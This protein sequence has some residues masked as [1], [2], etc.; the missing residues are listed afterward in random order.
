MSCPISI[1]PT[2]ITKELR[3]VLGTNDKLYA[4][5]LSEVVNNEQ[6]T[7]DF[8]EWCKEKLNIVPDI[9][10]TKNKK[11]IVDAIITYYNEQ[12]PD[13]N[14]SSRIQNES[15]EVGRFGYTSIAAREFAKRIASNYALDVYHQI[16]HE[17]HTTIDGML[18]L[19]KEKT[20]K[21]ITKKSFVASAITAKLKKEI[22][23]RLEAKGITKEDIIAAFNDNNTTQLETWFEEDATIQD[24]NV[25]STYK[26]ML[27]NREVFFTEVFRDS[28][29]GDLRFDKDDSIDSDI[30]QSNLELQELNDEND[31][32]SEETNNSVTEDKDN[33]INILNNKDGQYN[34][35][36]THVNTSVKSYLSSLKRLNSTVLNDGKYDYDTNNDLGVPDCMNAE[37]CSAVLYSY[38]DFTNVDSMIASIR[39]IANT[40]PGF[41]S[42]IQMADYLT[43]DRDFAYKIYT[44]FGKSVIS[45]LET[46]VDSNVGNVRISNRRADKLTALRFE[47]I[48]SAKSTTILLDDLNSKSIYTTIKT[49][50]DSLVEAYN[51]TTNT[52]LLAKTDNALNK[53]VSELAAQLRR[54]YPTLTDTAIANYI[55][56]A[57]EGIKVDNAIRLLGILKDTI[58]SSYETQQNYHS[59]LADIAKASAE[60][61]KKHIAY[62]E[63]YQPLEELYAQEYISNNTQAAAISLANELV[64]YTVVK[65]ELNSRNVHGN[66]SSDVINNSMI[67][68]IINTLKS[69]EG[70]KNYGIYK[71]QSRQYDFSNIMI[72][73]K[74][75]NGNIINY[76]LFTQDENSQEFKPTSYAT[77][78]L[79]VR[80][81]NGA[82]ETGSD[83][84]VLY[85]EMSKGDYIATSFTNF[86]N[87][88][89]IQ[90]T[91]EDTKEITFAEYFMRIPSDAPKNF[92]ICAPKYSIGETEYGKND[93]LFYIENE[94]EA[95]NKINAAV[96]N[97]PVLDI[98]HGTLGD[99]AIERNLNQLIHHATAVNLSNIEFYEKK[100]LNNPDAKLG[101][102]VRLNFKHKAKDGVETEY[103]LEGTLGKEN[104][105]Y[106]L[107]NPI[108]KGFVESTSSEVARALEKH[109]KNKLIKQ[110]VIKRTINTNHPIYKQF[111]NAF[112]QELTDAASALNAIFKTR[113]GYVILD[114]NHQPIF[115]DGFAND[116][117]TA[118]KLYDTYHVG[119]G[120][121]ILENGKLTGKV[122]TSDRFILTK[123]YSTGDI[124]SENYGEAILKEAFNFLYGGASN[125]YIHTTRGPKG[126]KVVLTKAQESIVTKHLSRFINDYISE[127]ENRINNYSNLINSTLLTDNN[128]A[129]YALN[130][131]LM[132][133]SFNDLFEGD[134]KFYKDTQTFLKRAKESQGSGVPYGIVDYNMDLTASRTQIPSR[135]NQKT[136]IH[137]F[138]DGHTENIEIGQYNK[139]RG[140]TIKN[141]IRTS[142]EVA[143]KGLNNAKE[144]GILTKKLV[145]SLENSGLSTTAATTKAREMMS[146]YHNTKVNDAQSYIT[147]EE[148]VR[149]ISARGQLEEYMPLIEAVLD[150][151]KPLDAKTIGKFIQVQKNFYYDQYYNPQ[152]GCIVPRQIKN[153]EFVLVPRLIKG[154]QL[155]QVYNMMKEQGIDQLNTEETSKAGKANILTIWDNDGNIT[156][157]NI[158]DFN[159][160][161]AQAIELYNYNYLYTQQETPQHLNA[162][163]KAGIQIMKKIL[164]NISP[165]SKL[166]PYKTK[167]FELYCSNIKESFTDLID[168]LNLETDENGNL[169][170]DEN[171]NIKGLNYQIFFDKLQE[172]VARLG[173]DSNM[174][175]YVTLAP[176]QMFDNAQGNIKPITLMPTFMSNVSTKLENIAQSMFNSSITRQTLPG[177]HVAQVT[178]VGWKAANM[179]IVYKLNENGKG[180]NLKDN[181]SEEE[182]K[183]V[184]IKNQMYYTKTKDNIGTSKELKYHP[185]GE[186]Y[187]EILLPKANF[188]FK[189]TK[190]DGSLKTDEELL[191]ELQTA[192]LDKMIGYRIPT[193]GKQ[194]ICVMKVVGFV[195][196]ALGSTIIVPDD[197]VSQTGSDFDIDSVYGI[198]YT[199][200]INKITGVIEKIDYKTNTTEQDYFSYLRHKLQH[201]L[202]TK[203]KNSIENL[204]TAIE[205]ARN[206]EYQELMETESELYHA[207]P[208][209][210]RE[211]IKELQKVDKKDKTPLEAY[212]Q[213]NNQVIDGLTQYINNTEL[214]DDVKSQV[215]QYIDTRNNINTFINNSTKEDQKKYVE[216]KA[217]ILKERLDKIEAMAKKANLPTYIQFQAMSEVERNTRE[218]RNNELLR[219]MIEILSDE[220]SLEENLS[221]SNF[222]DIIEARDSVINENIQKRR[223]YRSTFNIFDQV[224]YQE[225]VMSGAKLKAFSVTRDTFC[226]ICNTVQ[227]TL[228]SDSYVTINY[229]TK[230]T[231]KILEEAF[232]EENVDNIKDKDNHVIGYKVTHTRFGWSNTNKNV[233]GKLITAY[234]SQTTAH[235]LDAVK[236]GAIPNVND[237]TFQVYKLFPDL[238]SDYKTGISF[239]MQ[240]GISRIVEGYNARNSIYSTS[241]KNPIHYAIYSI[242]KQLAEINNE[243]FDNKASIEDIIKSLQKYNSN[244]AKLFNITDSKFVIS[245][246]NYDIAKLPIDGSK[247]QDRLQNTGIFAAT[248]PVEEQDKLLFDLGVVLQYNK[249]YNLGSVIGDYARV[250]NPD[251]FGAK[252]SIFETNKVFDDISKLAANIGSA[253]IV[254]DKNHNTKNMISAIYPGASVGVK[255]YSKANNN[256]DSVYPSLHYFLKYATATSIIINRN[257]F[258]TQTPSFIEKVTQL[259]QTFSGTDK[260]LTEKVYKDYQNYILSY[261]YNQTDAIKNK[262]IYKKCVGFVYEA[263]SDTEIERNRIYGYGK[264]PDI[265]VK[266]EQGNYI[267]FKVNDINNPSELE[268]EQFATLSPA[269]KVFWIQKHFRESGVFK[270]IRTSLF[271]T[272]QY[273]KNKAG[274]QTI[275]FIEGNDNIETIYNE[276]EKCYFNDNPLIALATLDIVKYGF[277]VE[278]FKMK[279]N[280]V[281]KV[282][283][284]KVLMTSAEEGGTGIVNQIIGQISNLTEENAD[285][286]QEG[287]VR[288]HSTIKEINTHKVERN[289]NGNFELTRSDSGIIYINIGDKNAYNL[290]TRYGFVYPVFIEGKEYT[291]VNQYVKLRF[292]KT[293]ELYKI[294]AL[295]NKIVA[296]PLNK[297]EANEYDVWSVNPQ[298]HKYE[299]SSYYED[300]IEDWFN[301][302][303]GTTFSD[304]IKRHTEH[305]EIHKYKNTIENV[306]SNYARYFDINAKQTVD[307][308]GF[309]DVINKTTEYFRNNP[310]GKL[311]LRSRAL[312]KYI[313]HTGEINGS[314]QTINNTKYII[315]KF[316]FDRYNDIYLSKKGYEREI[317]EK[318]PQIVDI[319]QKARDGEYK[320][321]D[322][323]VIEPYREKTPT[324]TN[325][326][327]ETITPNEIMHSS[328]TELGSNSMRTM[329]RR[330]KSENDVE[331]GKA[332]KRLRDKDITSKD[333]SVKL[334]LDEVIPITAE[335]VEVTTN[336]LLNDLTYFLR[337]D[338]GEYHSVNDEFT[339]QQIRNNPTERNRFLKTLLD[340]RAFVRNYKMINELDIDSEDASLHNALNRIKEA[341]NKLQNATIINN[342]E[343]RFATDFLAKLSNNPN[344]QS[345]LISILDGYHSA[346]AFD[347][348]VNDLQET[349]NPLL[350]IVTKE[351]MGDIRAKE[352]LASKRI[353]E[354]KTQLKA[355]KDNAKNAGVTIDWSHIIDDYGKFIQDYNQAFIDKIEELRNA[356][357]TAKAEFDEGSIEHLK[358]KFEYDKFKLNHVNQEIVDDYYRSK[359]ELEHT[360]LTKFPTVYSAYRKLEAKRRELLSHTV[361][362][363]LEESYQEKLR[364][365]KRQ[366]DNLTAAYYYNEITGEFEEKKSIDDPENPFTGEE[367]LTYS[368]EASNAIKKYLADSKNLR[369]TYFV[370][371]SKYGFD[372][373]LEKNLDIIRSF[374]DKSDVK[375][376]ILE[377]LKNDTYAKARLW[378]EQN[379]RFSVTPELKKYIDDAFA[380]FREKKSGRE[381]L[382]KIAK[383][384]E[385]YDNFGIIDA[386]K[387][388][389]NDIDKIK[390]EETI[391]YNIREGE[392]HNDRILISNAPKN[393]DV[394]HR[395]FYEKMKV[396][397]VENPEYLKL[398]TEIND[399]LAPYY[400]THS[401]ILYTYEISEKDLYDL[402]KLYDK[403][404]NTKKT[405]DATNGKTVR[406]YINKNVDFIINDTEYKVQKGFAKTKGDRY[407]KLWQQLC[408]RIEE[409][410]DGNDSVI[411]NRRI[412][413]YA[414]P[415]GYKPDGT[416]DNSLVDKKKTEAF[417]IIHKYTTTHPTEYY[418]K[419]FREM[420][421]KSNEEFNEWYHR[422]HIYNPYNHTYQPLQCWTHLEY[423]PVADDGMFGEAGIWTPAYNQMNSR[424]SNGKDKFGNPDGSLDVTNHNYKENTSTA[425][426]FKKEGFATREDLPFGEIPDYLKDDTD[427]TNHDVIINDYEKQIKDLFQ[428]TLKTLALTDSAK[429]YIN[430]GYMVARRKNQEVDAKFLA[431]EAAKF[432]GWIEGASGREAW[433]E[434]IDYATDKTIDMPM[435]SMLKSKDSIT[436]NYTR[437]KR[438]DNET[439]ETYNKRVLEYE[440]A[441]KEAEEQNRKVHKDLLDKNWEAVM[442]DFINKACHFNAI[443]DNKYMLFYAKNMLDKLDVYVKNEGFNNL[444]RDN[445]NST[446]DEN[447][448]VTRK[449]TRLQEQYVNWLRRLVYDQWKK[450]NNK[451]TRTANLLQSM[452]SAKFMMLNVTGGIA[453]VTV[454]ETQILAEAFANEYFGTK[455]WAKGKAIWSSNLPNFIADM[456]SDTSTSLGSAI[457]KFMNVVDFDEVTGNVHIDNKSKYIERARDLAFSPQSIGEHFM[458][459]GAMFSMMMSHKLYKNTDKELN[460]KTNY[461]LKNE[462]EVTRDANEKALDNLLTDTLRAKWN[463][464]KKYEIK[465]A[466]STKEYAWF[467]KDLTTEFVNIYFNAEEK[468]KFN[469]ECRKLQKLYLNDFKDDTK[470]PTLY[471]QLRLGNNG[472]LDFANGSIMESLGDEAYQILGRFKGRVISVNKKIHGVY[473]R[474]GAAKWESYWW[475]GIVMQY[476]KHLYPG[477]MKRYRRQGYFNEER[478]T[479]EKGCYASIKDFLALPLHKIA[480]AK[481]LQ[482]E[483][484]MSDSE[485]LAVKGIQ[486]LIR[487]YIEFA[488]HIRTNWN[489]I[490]ESERANIRRSLGDILGVTAALCLAIAL[491][492]AAGDDDEGFIYNL[493]MYEADR[494]ASESFMYNPFGAASEAEK[495]WSSPVAVQSGISDLIHSAGF[496]SQWIIQGDEFDPYY[497]TGLY[498]GEN[499]LWV[500]VRRQIP[501]YHA[502]NML[503]RL[504]RNNHYYKLGDNMLSIVPVKDIA[505]WIRE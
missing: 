346:G 451:L 352:M 360:M 386:T 235:I 447:H 462:A 496:I 477:I 174:M 1:K 171:G 125:T 236:E 7:T 178:N 402:I 147:F 353:Q 319:I 379:A 246:N 327:S 73:H 95:K 34:N 276:F 135:L 157:E 153:A 240:P 127:A 168:E 217:E 320:V 255:Y 387:F 264:Q 263:N 148:W 83:K 152:L 198:N 398:V 308:G 79:K 456:Y 493:F 471:S 275:E 5:Y 121:T 54:Y 381:R 285:K 413:G 188:G 61:E 137:K 164:D 2:S 411:A 212:T 455:T 112:I 16:L 150:E 470:H 359:L 27:G 116:K 443:Q 436:V 356:R 43:N 165:N 485:I 149:R 24:K 98:E 312:A 120:K 441:K 109:F 337:D 384:R 154:T 354:F 145:T 382:S 344:I 272:S 225:D 432:V 458:Q 342:A 410:K 494:L 100:R 191:K 323:F 101:D 454:G 491:R 483:N 288:S 467:R 385:A 305:K 457:V 282:I 296:Y 71:S 68:N 277:A 70:L 11:K 367:K 167:F 345:D 84:S 220:T 96:N 192:G 232:G 336:K 317:K 222:D 260:Q 400:D 25:I 362:G 289:K 492:V 420:R 484:D 166:Y 326:D 41:E 230:Y 431:K 219:C 162:K 505:N 378:L 215:Q 38:C 209:D 401:G 311:Y 190:A 237:Y 10:A 488:F 26:E 376:P 501:M 173:L 62:N 113:D 78:L 172:E 374:E 332:L 373:E 29:L 439:E 347:A 13:I 495:L 292:G 4:T 304:V 136:F 325:D 438:L 105:K 480:F 163:N 445:I 99:V 245:L 205:D 365:V 339:I 87:S 464:F 146:G 465:D 474:L 279:R 50:L 31:S 229:S 184:P 18:K 287:F 158:N 22:I 459:N 92:V 156:Q 273:Y 453:N 426:N 213:Q 291:K 108:F 193:E 324:I 416:G 221:R 466:N 498:A 144:D 74:D 218:A 72:E 406:K 307:T 284:N 117:A 130:H 122:F 313:K 214:S 429:R 469:E 446:E 414:V 254:V 408:E 427:Y 357:D 250:C 338:T 132:Y 422:N 97:L 366:I 88:E 487:E 368:Y 47:Y 503:E 281:N 303:D 430:N 350:Q 107:T 94:I 175:D 409:D 3:K 128:I 238:G 56:N 45:K 126:V 159:N 248:S 21:T 440:K 231:R 377:L 274:A 39:R 161:A 393:G 42:F 197:W 185:N 472:K 170:L 391:N 124:V 435:T 251:K 227:P 468:R 224:D 226:S 257:L 298:Y 247:Y 195:D 266:N 486:N 160:N 55:T 358:A 294:K 48:N 405:L 434:D 475:G 490:P 261:F 208:D 390:E 404:E 82:T 371:D 131:Y 333:A 23:A 423:T 199:S 249:L 69:E 103:I 463:A 253:L 348:W 394:F 418:Y 267:D 448:Y 203:V 340:A 473:D 138:A 343:E 270:Y 309:E 479:I 6:F 17:K 202:D 181:I 91:T 241:Y 30:T 341:I 187:I 375:T 361:N 66:Q 310:K 300:L 223:K 234:S 397:G 183:K 428:N 77:E 442:E 322:A 259:A 449:D 419:K 85:S 111:Y 395:K 58:D 80:L 389:D 104:N 392:A 52:R 90:H 415:K 306:S 286:L 201:K 129:E 204:K 81:F 15:T 216:G 140:V 89:P 461:I 412:F 380:I 53:I 233:V 139:F 258:E 206:E 228:S 57:H 9:N 20:G 177:F 102:T 8:Q 399:I 290:A 110:G 388:T 369:D 262:V 123:E 176:D 207:L 180:R 210:I 239:I 502:W 452:T 244:L 142:A 425:G 211:K 155:E 349:S 114:E 351:V 143:V 302:K 179:P 321:N 44:T 421:A 331:A 186:P 396:E 499:K 280:A 141:T 196:D 35:F 59:R 119:K 106:I 497:K 151:T 417:K 133:I 383:V 314:V 60:K 12:Y 444:Q 450:P 315:S 32:S 283:S 93:G 46:V 407:F 295:E 269:Q 268:I 64:N 115:N 265:R 243:K 134:T 330:Q 278:G 329:Y 76:G 63:I 51:R 200:R 75:E 299:D 301:V 370:Q 169:K 476:H 182:F 335:Y 316:N 256:D 194:S 504:E 242:A 433:Y 252:Q 460:G 33:S 297:L 65:T 437:P 328:V 500:N 118:R 49:K 489:M 14:Y 318:D 36:M 28:R 293:I 19:M 363:T 355:I 37:E 403:I 40:L 424:P 271:N 481:K 67:T 372:K 334:H 482:T 189:T 364:K 86:F 478:G